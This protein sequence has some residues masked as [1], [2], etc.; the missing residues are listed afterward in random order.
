MINRYIGFNRTPVLSF[1]N[2]DTE[3]KIGL[4]NLYGRP[5][6]ISNKQGNSLEG[7]LLT[8]EGNKAFIKP[9]DQLTGQTIAID[10][11]G[12]NI[13]PKGIIFSS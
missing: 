1:S 3:E 7:Q 10:L 13:T 12:I 5:V 11:D 6:I 8:I 4:Q 9:T 2:E